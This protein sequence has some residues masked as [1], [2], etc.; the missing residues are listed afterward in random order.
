MLTYADV[1]S[2]SLSLSL[3]LAV[4]PAA[5]VA[6]DNRGLI[7]L[8]LVPKGSPLRWGSLQ[9]LESVTL[10]VQVSLSRSLA[11]SLSLARA[12]SPSAARGRDT[13][14]AGEEGAGSAQGHTRGGAI[15]VHNVC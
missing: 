5:T 12:L 10:R 4:F 8:Q 6:T 3:S 7:P 13:V 1:C 15:Q 11:L 14:C 9:L 2:L